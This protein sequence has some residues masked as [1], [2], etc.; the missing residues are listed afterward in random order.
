MEMDED[1][2]VPLIMGRPFV[3][4]AKFVIEVDN[5]KVTMRTQYD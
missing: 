4:T 3:K 1:E 2:D 5:G